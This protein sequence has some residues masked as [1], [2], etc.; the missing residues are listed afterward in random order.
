MRLLLMP[1]AACTPVEQFYAT[2]VSS[3]SIDADAVI[4]Q[5]LFLPRDTTLARYMLWLSDYLSVCHKSDQKA[6]RLGL[7]KTI[8]YSQGTLVFWHQRS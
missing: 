4:F 2:F 1:D 5:L 3:W 7:T 8:Y 6:E